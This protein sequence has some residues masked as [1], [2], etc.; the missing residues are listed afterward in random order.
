MS[1]NMSILI[2]IAIAL[3]AIAMFATIIVAMKQSARVIWK[4]CRAC[5]WWYDDR[6]NLSTR[7]PS[8]WHGDFGICV[9]CFNRKRT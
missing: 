8:D 4:R 1:R 6:G 9:D 5:M 7:Q 2:D 3:I